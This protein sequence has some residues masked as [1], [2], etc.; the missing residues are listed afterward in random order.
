MVESRS[1]LLSQKIKKLWNK[2]SKIR[3]SKYKMR[4]VYV[5]LLILLLI[6]GMYNTDSS[7]KLIDALVKA[8][9]FLILGN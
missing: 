9:G 2:Y 6:Y 3:F 8:F 5:T 1:T 4:M 7:V